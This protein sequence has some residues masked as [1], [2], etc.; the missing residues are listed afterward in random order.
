[1]AYDTDV[2]IIGAGPTGLALAIALRQH[3]VHVRIIDQAPETKRQARAAVVWQRA[4][5][6]LRDLGT[7]D[8][9]LAEGL[10]LR[11]AYVYHNDRQLGDLDMGRLSTE[12]PQ[13]LIIEQDRIESLLVD[14]LDELGTKV[15]WSTKAVDVRHGDD[16][17][18]VDVHDGEGRPATMSCSWLVGCEG[19]HSLVRESL[20]IPFEG[21]PRRGLQVV[22][23]NAEVTWK[24]ERYQHRGYFFLQQGASLG[25]FPRP[26]GGYRFFCFLAKDT[27]SEEPLTTEEMQALIAEVTH[28]PELR[29]RPTQPLWSNRARFQDRMARSFRRGRALLVGDSAHVWAPIGGHGLNTALRGAH[30][31]GWKLARVHRGEMVNALLDTYDIEQRHTAQVVMREMRRNVLELPPTQLM[32]FG[33]DI[34]MPAA[35][36]S[37]MVERRIESA[38]SDLHLSHRG[39]PLAVDHLDSREMKAGDRI[40]DLPVIVDGRRRHLHE[41][42]SYDRWTLLA[43]TD[44]DEDLKPLHATSADRRTEISTQ[45][46]QLSPD[47][48]DDPAARCLALVRPDSHI[49]LLAPLPGV[50]ALDEYLTRWTSRG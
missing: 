34:A 32:M 15:E 27:E 6:V 29:I 24:F 42:L 38:I 44:G 48:S 43:I 19:A 3:G 21:A 23:I 10:A 9:F 11:R 41:F 40:P 14:R 46:L 37:S 17:A 13:P 7:A 5:E 39:S 22:Q 1:M 28:D 12:F 20:S 47:L 25:A 8:R 16:H 45:R 18:E 50:E 4:L 35:L 30:N 2:L 31:L 49:G 36:M 33:L 26:K